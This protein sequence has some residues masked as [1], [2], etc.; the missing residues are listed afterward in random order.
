MLPITAEKITFNES[1]SVNHRIAMKPIALL[2]PLI[3]LLT[4][5]QVSCAEARPSAKLEVTPFALLQE[6]S[7]PADHFTQGLYYDGERWLES[8]GLYGRSWLAEYTDPG[9]NPLRR[10]W[11]AGDRFAEGLAV[12]EDRIYLLTY[13]AGELQIYNRKDLNLLDTRSYNGEG[14]GLTTDGE[15]LIMSNG[16]GTLTFRDPQTFAVTRNLKVTGGDERWTRLNELEYTHGLIWANIWQ[17]SR[18]IAIDPQSGAVKGILN[19]AELQKSSL[20]NQHNVDAVANGIAW[21]QTR[22]GLWVTGKYWPKIYLIRPVGF[23]FQ[24]VPGK[25]D[26]E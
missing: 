16:S 11:L 5:S 25:R 17:D 18:I 15:H 6:I 22:N 12:L 19:L 9:G 10:K 26:K 23:G 13:R 24:P 8:S 3:L 14:W 20:G 2:L 4:L 7:R 1:R 21:D